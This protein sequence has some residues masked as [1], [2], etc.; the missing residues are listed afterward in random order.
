MSRRFISAIALV[1]IFILIGIDIRM[2]PPNPYKSPPLIAFG[3]GLS[4]SGGFCGS[5][6]N[7]GSTT[8]PG[9]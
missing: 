4:G 3:S 6:L 8:D 9:Q 2:T 7:E 1:G 5:L